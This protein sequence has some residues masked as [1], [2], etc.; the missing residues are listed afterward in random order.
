MSHRANGTG[1]GAAPLDLRQTRCPANCVEIMGV[2]EA[3]PAGSVHEFWVAADS[4][5]DI[6]RML[7]ESGHGVEPLPPPDESTL[8]VRVTRRPVTAAEA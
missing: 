2:L 5:L 1:D 7:R 8:A 6:P 4:A 3:S